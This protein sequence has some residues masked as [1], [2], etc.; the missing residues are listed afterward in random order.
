M[1][2]PMLPGLIEYGGPLG[3]Q[4]EILIIT[5]VFKTTL[6][7]VFTTSSAEEQQNLILS[8]NY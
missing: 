3:V 8:V 1:G 5:C 7:P 6:F 4:L 2:R